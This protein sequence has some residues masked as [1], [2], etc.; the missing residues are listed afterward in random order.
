MEENIKYPIY[1]DQDKMLRS[2]VYSKMN[3]YLEKCKSAGIDQSR[4]IDQVDKEYQLIV[5]SNLSG[6]YYSLGIAFESIKAKDM[7][8]YGASNG[9]VVPIILNLTGLDSEKRIIG[10]FESPQKYYPELFYGIAKARL[11]S[12][13]SCIRLS[14]DAYR[15]V[16]KK[17]R[18][19]LKESENWNIG[20]DL[21]KLDD[22]FTQRSMGLM[23]SKMN[24]FEEFGRYEQD[25]VFPVE[26]I[27]M[28]DPD[29]M[30]VFCDGS[31]NVRGDNVNINMV[32]EG[33]KKILMRVQPSTVEDI[34]YAIG[35]CIVNNIIPEFIPT[36]DDINSVKIEPEGSP[37]RQEVFR[38][39]KLKKA[40]NKN[41]PNMFSKERKKCLK[42]Q[43]FSKAHIDCIAMKYY[44]LAYQVHY[45]K[46]RIFNPAHRKSDAS[47]EVI[48][49]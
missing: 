13:P 21:E 47:R 33:L 15:E 10:I 5:D 34:S 27:P 44:L 9:A 12:N 37:E 1:K 20:L 38:E 41:D 43:I 8:A 24:S 16:L 11:S 42:S 2:L 18:F 25:S 22:V 39:T 6:L 48:F 46:L 35:L 36:D 30:K 7:I 17:L 28:D 26:M 4:F 31:I 32:D 40:I 49:E 19:V 29:T 3:N 45:P 23:L 14:S